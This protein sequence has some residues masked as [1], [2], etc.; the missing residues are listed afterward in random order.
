MPKVSV[1][2]P[3]YN[4][5]MYIQECLESVRLQTLTD[6]ECIII[7]DGSTDNSV[8]IIKQFVRADHRFKLIRQKNAGV[9]AARNRGLDVARGD[10]I[11][12]LDSDDC[13]LPIALESMYAI[14]QKNNVDLV[15]ADSIMVPDNFRF[16]RNLP[17][18][19]DVK[20]VPPITVLRDYNEVLN[21][22]FQVSDM[23]G[24]TY[25]NVWIWHQMYRR[26]TLGQERF[27][28]GLCPGDDIC[29]MLDIMAVVRSVAIARIPVTYHRLSQTS[30]MNN[31]LRHASLVTFFT[32]ALEYIHDKVK[33]R[34]PEWALDVFLGGFAQ[35]YFDAALK[36]PLQE[37]K[38]RAEGANVLKKTLG[39]E[40]MSAK[41][42]NKF[43]MLLMRMM[44][45]VFAT[46][47]DKK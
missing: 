29:Y 10:W 1:I 6:F 30:V 17:R 39:N 18:D 21:S 25:K 36:L 2:I 13:Y 19:F 20:R 27:V 35:Y 23:L 14:G 38:Y 42:F 12:Y 28:Y 45:F 16:T 22:F 9:G 41:Y 7:D 33:P 31:G 47:D 3:N 44:I 46:K 8:E 43:Q 37:K 40:Y 24:E 32:P 26:R 11:A 5:G 34:L 15:N 4:N